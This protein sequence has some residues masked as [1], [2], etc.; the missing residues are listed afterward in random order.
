M[1][2]ETLLILAGLGHF[3]ILIASL[4]T[5][6]ALDWK[7][8]LAP[9]HPFLRT[10]FWVYGVFIVLT[11]TGFGVLT[12]LNAKAMAAGDPVARSLAAFIAVFWS[13]RLFVQFFVFDAREFLTTTTARKL[14][15]HTLTV[16]FI[17]QAAV[18]ILAALQP[19]WDHA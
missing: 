14:G 7:T 19:L 8:H 2:L 9:L 18:Y 5:P 17:A 10:L 16:A 13:A 6:K 12:L 11:I 15:Y 1:N 3:G 4:L